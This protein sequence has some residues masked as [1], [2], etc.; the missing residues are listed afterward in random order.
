M[1]IVSGRGNYAL[2]GCAHLMPRNSQTSQI[3]P[4]EKIR[5]YTRQ[6]SRAV[7]DQ[8]RLFQPASCYIDMYIFIAVT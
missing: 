8:L 3:G 4:G 7:E 5:I 2:L 6:K 1:Y